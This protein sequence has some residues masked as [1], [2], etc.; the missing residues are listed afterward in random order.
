MAVTMTKLWG[1]H[2]IKFGG[3]YRHN[4][5][6]LLQTQ[7][8][9]GPRGRYQFGASQTGS[10]ANAASQTN[11]ANS[12]AAFLLDRPSNVSRD[13]AVIDK[14]GT[15][16]SSM[17]SFIHDK[18]QVG[19]KMTIDLGL[20]HEYYTPLRGIEGQGGLS[21]YDPVTNSLLVS[22]YGSISESIN[23]KSNWRNFNPRTGVSYRPTDK[24]VIRAGYGASTA[25]FPDNTYAYNF[26]VKQNNVFNA[27]NAFVPPT[28]LSMAAGFP[29]PAV[30]NIPQ[31]GIIDAGS[32]CASAQ[33]AVLRHPRGPEG[34]HA[35]LVE[36]RVPARARLELHG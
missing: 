2:T 29:A 30:A 8:Q 28:G 23:V 11:L 22:G 31:N 5:D 18:W 6:Y 26:P 36:R 27:A 35:A 13:L 24:T 32:D 33:P 25:P 17:F 1:N 12:F 4:E 7:D 19:P 16:Y 34:R 3:D 21:N 20:R 15:I 9:G 14:P 10:P